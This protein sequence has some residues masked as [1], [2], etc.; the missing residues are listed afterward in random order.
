MM[1]EDDPA[2]VNHTTLLRSAEMSGGGPRPT[3]D[4]YH[5]MI[6]LGPDQSM[7]QRGADYVKSPAPSSVGIL[8]TYL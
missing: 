5:I 8:Y 3:C 1:M 4:P 6:S 2:I 7:F